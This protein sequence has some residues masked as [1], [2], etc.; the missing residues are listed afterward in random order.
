VIGLLPPRYGSCP[1]AKNQAVR[2]TP[3]AVALGAA[4]D[5]YAQVM[6]GGKELSHAQSTG[7]KAR[8]P[9]RHDQACGVSPPSGR[10]GP[11]LV[12]LCARREQGSGPIRP[13]RDLPAL[14]VVGDFD[15]F[16]GAADT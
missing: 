6:S 10:S 12:L 4:P 14:G 13:L 11:W 2:R 15:H 5:P 8:R 1:Q 16:S 7:E 9:V 3:T